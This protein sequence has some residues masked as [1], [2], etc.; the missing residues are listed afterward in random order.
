[1]GMFGWL[2]KLF[3]G[4]GKGD[5]GGTDE[6][7]SP[8]SG[9]QGE[10]GV[11]GATVVLST[12][13]VFTA[14]LVVK[15]GGK[16]GTVYDLKEGRITLGSDSENDIQLDDSSVSSPH[17]M[18]RVNQGS[19]LLYDMG[20]TAG[21]WVNGNSVQGAFLKDGS[22]VSI[23]GTDLF[24]SKLGGE[25]GKPSKGVLLVRSGPSTGKSFN[26]GENDLVIGR[27]PGEDGAQVDD[28]AI[29]QRHAMVRTTEHGSV[30]YD[31]GSF[32]GTKVDEVSLAGTALNSGDIVKVGEVELQFVQ[33]QAKGT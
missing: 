7:D 3:G 16:E 2:T 26:V 22:R 9:L 10:S 19:Y 29:S 12:V 1:M 27:A 17:I 25:E 23:G 33:E 32:N 5:G 18:I 24:Y 21:T 13:P 20:S 4:G 30:I 31:L 11:S 15:G 14:W 8:A 28:P 6:L